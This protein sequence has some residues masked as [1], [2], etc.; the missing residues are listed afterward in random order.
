MKILV[1]GDLL[2]NLQSLL[3]KIK[4]IEKKSGS[5]D[6]LFCVGSFFSGNDDKDTEF[7]SYLSGKSQIQIPT[8][9]LGPNDPKGTS[10]YSKFTATGTEICPN[11][12]YLGTHGVYKA[13][14]GLRIAYLSGVY[15]ATE[16]RNMS[17][18]QSCYFTEME[19]NYLLGYC[20]KEG[21]TGVDLFLTSEWPSQVLNLTGSSVDTSIGSYP[22]SLACL[23]LKPRYHFAA[24]QN[25]FLERSPYRNHTILSERSTHVTRFIALANFGNPDK[26]NKALYAFNTEPITAIHPLVLLTQPIGTTDS[27]YT[28]LQTGSEFQEEEQSFFFEKTR[29]RSNREDMNTDSKRSRQ[30]SP[31]DSKHKFKHDV[32]DSCWFC[33]SS[34]DVE[35]HL[36]VHIQTL[37]YLALAKGGLHR[38]HVLILP[39]SH[40]AAV[41]E[42]PSD[43]MEELIKYKFMLKAYFK[44]KGFGIIL[45]ERNFKSNHLQ[46][47][48]IPVPEHLSV[49]ILRSVCVEYCKDAGFEF[50]LLTANTILADVVGPGYPY[51][52]IEFSDGSSLL[53]HIRKRF[54]IHFARCIICDER[55]L[56][57]PDNIDWK[58]CIIS[59]QEETELAKNFRQLFKAVYLTN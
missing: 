43:V 52:H 41:N 7:E 12:I 59:K 6:M 3:T 32:I 5:F 42:A 9:I 18:E 54:D 53:H 48:A 57:Q 47:Q 22:I 21:I 4:N 56:N 37:T 51:L 40:I 38:D 58:K 25:R 34:P 50:N 36:V 20:R 11:L 24:L 30:T 46:I 31:V 44:S 10:S 49:D 55:I 35:K 26:Q 16:F 23:A 29:K 45:Y 13:A 28:D 19:L 27:P 2:G 15:K 1:C 33:L 17:R 8:F 14:N 39:I